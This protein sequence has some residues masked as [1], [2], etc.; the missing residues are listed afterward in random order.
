MKKANKTKQIVVRFDEDTYAKV[1]KFAEAEHRGM[2]E[3]IRHA[4]LDYIERCEA[5]GNPLK[6]KNNTK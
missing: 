2:G 5:S 4:A 6:K 3:F 1:N